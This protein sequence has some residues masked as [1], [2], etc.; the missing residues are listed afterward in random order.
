MS[1]QPRLERADYWLFLIQPSPPLAESVE[2]LHFAEHFL[3]KISQ[4]I[5]QTTANKVIEAI[6]EENIRY[7][8]FSVLSVTVFEQSDRF[9]SPMRLVNVLESVSLFYEACSLMGDDSPDTL[10][11]IACDSGSDK[12]FDFLGIAKVMEC[13]TKLIESLWDRV[14]FYREHQFE[15][16]LDLITKSLPIIVE[17]NKLEADNL[18][19]PERAEILKRNI[20]EG[21]RKFIQSGASIPQIESKS[22]HDARSLM[23]PMPKLLAS[24]FG[25][26]T[27]GDVNEPSSEKDPVVGNVTNQANIDKLTGEERAQLLELLMKSKATD[28]TDKAG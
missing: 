18:I 27:I 4:L 26:T 12:S 9:S 14:V 20:F 5:E 8:N 6:K 25:E 1:T 3:P 22:H 13:V 24:S 10:S 2:V 28:T 7:K 19:E 11:V 15:E 16:R 23:S 17:I 21:A